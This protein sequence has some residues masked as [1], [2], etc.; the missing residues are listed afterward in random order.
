MQTLKLEILKHITTGTKQPRGRQEK[1]LHKHTNLK[2]CN[3]KYKTT[4]GAKKKDS[5]AN[6]QTGKQ[7]TKG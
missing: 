2:T 1:S 7:I 4:D 5:N 6:I 3:K